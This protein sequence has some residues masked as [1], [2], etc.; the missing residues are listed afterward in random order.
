MSKRI[1]RMSN[2][3]LR[4]VAVVI[5]S[6]V[7]LGVA[8]GLFYW[9]YLVKNQNEQKYLKRIS[10]LENSLALLK[11]TSESK[12]PEV[13]GNEENKQDT[14]SIREVECSFIAISSNISTGDYVDIRIRYPDGSDYIVLAYKQ[15]IGLDS[16]TKKVILGLNEEELL[17]LNSAAVD[18]ASFTGSRVYMTKYTKADSLVSKVNYL[19]ASKITDLLVENPNIIKLKNQNN[20]QKR[21]VL[22]AQ[23]SQFLYADEEENNDIWEG[24][25]DDE[26]EDYYGYGDESQDSSTGLPEQYGGSIWD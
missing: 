4:K 3:T 12:N 5:I 6:I 20:K 7:F 26:W 16:D 9:F 23:L 1:R 22:E 14:E 8:I 21:Y 13:S 11:E 19:P 25:S 2:G 10:E 24:Y 17:M 15:V 18:L